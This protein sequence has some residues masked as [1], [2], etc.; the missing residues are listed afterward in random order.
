[1]RC[2][3]RRGLRLR[4]PRRLWGSMPETVYSIALECRDPQLARKMTR[5]RVHPQHRTAFARPWRD[6]II[7]DW[8]A[9]CVGYSGSHWRPSWD[10]L[11]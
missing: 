3:R 7:G 9:T 11:L 6:S 2:R 4:H 10:R 1:M 5:A 8:A